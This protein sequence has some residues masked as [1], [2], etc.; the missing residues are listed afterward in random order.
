MLGEEVLFV[1]CEMLR[2]SKE[3][4]NIEDKSKLLN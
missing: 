3:I 4:L 1:G 2:F